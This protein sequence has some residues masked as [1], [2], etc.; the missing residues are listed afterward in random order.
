MKKKI[1]VTK[2]SGEE[3]PFDAKKLKRS[4]SRAGASEKQTH[5]IVNQLH[6]LLYDGIPT[7]KIYQLAFARL[8]HEA[9]FIAARYRLKQAI[10]ELGPSGY[11]FEKFV[12][13]ILKR[14]GYSVE[15]GVHVMGKCVQ[16][17][18][19]V[20]A[21][22]DHHQFMIECK[23][24]NHRG[25]ICDVKIPLYIHSRFNDV[26]AAWLRTA[27]KEK[28]FYQ[29]WVVTN[30]KFSKD[31]VSYA[32]CSGLKLLGWDYP[33]EE[34]LSK[35]IDDAGLYPITCLTLLTR[36]EKQFLLEKK[37]VLC[38]ELCD[39]PQ[40]LKDVGI[41]DVKAMKVLEEVRTLC[42]KCN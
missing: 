23:Y 10:M 12:A 36:A 2:A 26:L 13:E 22:S 42:G 6:T 20:I 15:V 17:E 34:S 25:I 39:R 3:V 27:D 7:K 29:G 19:D 35:M 18:V 37:I 24:H 16:H 14:K 33:Q 28:I 30:T 40:L 1:I 32:N 5:S 31:A 8:K 11:P 41:S 38:S 21:R 4:L 9:G